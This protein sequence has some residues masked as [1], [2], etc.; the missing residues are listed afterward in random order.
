M[1]LVS[2]SDAKKNALYQ[3]YFLKLRYKKLFRVLFKPPLALKFEI[4]ISF[5]L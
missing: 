4:K 3:L 5:I 2:E 1:Q